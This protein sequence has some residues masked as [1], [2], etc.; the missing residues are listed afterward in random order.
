M[1]EKRDLRTVEARVPPSG[2]VAGRLN[3]MLGPVGLGLER[4]KETPAIVTE[5]SEYFTLAAQ[6]N[7][8]QSD[9]ARTI[10]SGNNGCVGSGRVCPKYNF[11]G[12]ASALR[13]LATHPLTDEGNPF[14]AALD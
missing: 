13:R 7:F 12:F 2:S 6:E 5:A 9:N 14:S 1:I 8:D 10:H 4:F 3:S 11:L